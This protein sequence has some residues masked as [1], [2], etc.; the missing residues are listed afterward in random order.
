MSA[1]KKALVTG[2]TRGIGRAIVKEF[3]ADSDYSHIAFV[4]A[5]SDERAKELVEELKPTGK[6]ILPYK[7]DASSFEQVQQTVTDAVGKM[8][9]LDVLV[10]NAGI[11]R[12]NLLLRMSE[13]DFDDVIKV[14]LK[15]V[16]N[17]TKAVLRTMI[18]QRYGRIINISSVVGI[19][20]NPGQANYVASK[21][22]VIG[23]TK[24]L[25]R[26]L[27]SRNITANAVAPG[28]ISTDMT[29]KL[30]D[31]QRDALVKNIPL[32]RVGDPQDVAKVVRFLCSNAADYITGQVITVDGGLTM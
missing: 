27:A 20:G 7:T 13:Q 6:E 25:A 14:N 24:S 10:N 22:G 15:S 18:K 16:F 28:Y 21:A 3:A 2:G 5:S 32:G 4:Y 9:G 12:D 11:T 29:D 17:F 19:I 23:F 31:E 30:T 26:E 8:G 1:N